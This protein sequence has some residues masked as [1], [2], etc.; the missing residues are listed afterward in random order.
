[1]PLISPLMPVSSSSS[2][3]AST[4]ELV[5]H[6]MAEINVQSNSRKV[7]WQTDGEHHRKLIPSVLRSVA[8]KL[9]TMT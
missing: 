1:M 2:S 6:C 8:N 5:M 7:G 9:K 4:P 3:G